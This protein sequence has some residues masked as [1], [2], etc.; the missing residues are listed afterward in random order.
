MFLAFLKQE[1]ARPPYPPKTIEKSMGPLLNHPQKPAGQESFLTVIFVLL[2]VG[3]E[4]PHFTSDTLCRIEVVDS[5]VVDIV[6]LKQS[7]IRRTFATHS[8]HLSGLVRL[9]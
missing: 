6:P 8:L 9:M 2:Q 3:P 4:S 5:A 1:E 7:C